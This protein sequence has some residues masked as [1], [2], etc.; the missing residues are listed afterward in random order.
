MKDIEY[1]PIYIRPSYG[2]HGSDWTLDRMIVDGLFPHQPTGRRRKDRA[3]D[4]ASKVVLS[5]G[6]AVAR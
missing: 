5:L 3:A 2:R 4:Y 6:T 1:K